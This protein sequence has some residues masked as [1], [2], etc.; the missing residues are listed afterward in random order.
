[1]IEL[2]SRFIMEFPSDERIVD[3]YDALLD[4]YQAAPSTPPGVFADAV[5]ARG[6]YRNDPGPILTAANLLVARN[7]DLDR[8]IRLAEKSFEA[9]QQ[10]ID[11]NLGAYKLAEKAQNSLRRSRASAADTVGWACFAKKDLRQA[12]AKLFEAE[13]LA[14]AQDATNQFHIAEFLRAGQQW[15]TAREHYFTCL[16]LTA[17]PSLQAAAKKSLADVC[18]KLGI[19]ASGLDKYLEAELTRRLDTR[20]NETLGSMLDQRAPSLKLADV[21]GRPFDLASLRGKAVLLNFF[22]SW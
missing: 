2:A 21:N 13:Q 8:A 14:R 6:K 15:E 5:E 10:W 19:D 17:P 22:T 9:A 16:S 12:E 1:M 7:T 20:R 18:V 4:A 3:V 11:Q